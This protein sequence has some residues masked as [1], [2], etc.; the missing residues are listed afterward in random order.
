MTTAPTTTVKETDPVYFLLVDDLEQNLLSL[1]ALLRRPGLHMLKAKSGPEALELLLKHDIA[2]ALLDVQMPGMDGFE[3]AEFMRGNMRTRHVPIIFLTAG[4]TDHNRR[5]HG[6][7]KGA[8]DF[9]HKPIEPDVL[10]SKAEVFFELH[11]Q[12]QE[13]TKQRD[14]LQATSDKSE[15]LLSESLKNAEALQE[16]DTKKNEFIAMLAHELRNPLA[17]VRNGI[18]ILKMSPQS[19]GDK[20][21]LDMMDRQVSHLVR[22]IDDLLDVSRFSKGKINL[23]KE[24][25]QIQEV[26]SLALETSRP[27]IDQ[28]NHELAVSIPDTNLYVFADRNRI[29]QAVSNLLNN[30]A[31]YTQPGG[32][33]SLTVSQ[34]EKEVTIDITDNGIG[35]P[36]DMQDKI[37]DLFTQIDHHD[38][39]AKGGLGIGLALVK[40]LVAL[41]NGNITV[42]SDGCGKGATFTLHLPLTAAP[43]QTERCISPPSTDDTLTDNPLRILVVDD[44]LPSAE[45]TGWMLEMIGHQITLAHDGDSAIQKANELHP[46]AILLDIGLPGMDGYDVCK[47]LRQN[48]AFKDTL[49]IAQ[50][51]WGQEKDKQ[52]AKAAGF[53]HHLVKPFS[54][55]Q[56]SE[57]LSKK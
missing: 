18:N 23:N 9:L 28:H 49:I 43:V 14:D 24:T 37:F 15:A 56:L 51:G 8:V 57:L 10:R 48:P 7:E 44:N 36:K 26:I 19:T 46:D 13:L 4:T 27:A 34:N 40:Q 54:I 31:K 22:L 39:K 12:K 2:L 5:F 3:L 29:S 21:I 47:A 35:I 52:L 1:E 38:K 16:S 20:N 50:T 45:T 41:H 25:L 30:A 17:P 42:H 55:D 53:D 11:K 32:K 33:I 6:Y